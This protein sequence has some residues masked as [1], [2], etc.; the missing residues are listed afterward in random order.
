LVRRRCSAPL[1]PDLEALDTAGVEMD[2][3]TGRSGDRESAREID[4]FVDERPS[5][6]AGGL[7]LWKKTKIK[8]SAF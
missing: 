3:D 4:E 1:P 7:V 2:A 5:A 8:P 6:L